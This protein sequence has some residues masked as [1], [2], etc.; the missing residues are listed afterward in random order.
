MK[1]RRSLSVFLSLMVVFSLTFA[2]AQG[3]QLLRTE[4]FYTSVYDPFTGDEI[5]T[6]TDSEILAFP[7]E[8]SL[9][10]PN[11]DGTFS[12]EITYENEVL[13]KVVPAIV[14]AREGARFFQLSFIA[15]VKGEEVSNPLHR[16]FSPNHVL[17]KTENYLFSIFSLFT[18]EQNNKKTFLQ[19]HQYTG[20]LLLKEKGF[21]MV[22][23][24][25][26]AKEIEVTFTDSYN[27]NIVF[28]L[29]PHTLALIK[30]TYED[31]NAL[32]GRDESFLTALDSHSSISISPAR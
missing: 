3:N 4:E 18:N 15:T 28:S 17:I 6:P 20:E 14:L 10:I 31:F 2:F 11:E 27:D 30:Q 32:G 23:E 8:G 13:V 16:V 26:K 29:S 5:L 21:V 9:D 1:T 24:I 25:L 19:E 12:S 22:E 7:V